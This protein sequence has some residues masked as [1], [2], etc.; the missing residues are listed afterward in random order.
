[1]AK[2]ARGRKANAKKSNF[3]VI[4][5]IREYPKE[6]ADKVKSYNEKYLAEPIEKGKK[7]LKTY[8]KKYIVKTFK[9]GRDYLEKP[10]RKFTD[11][12]D[13]LLARGR[14]MEKDA[15][16]KLDE[17]WEDGRDFAYKIPMV[18][19][20]EKKVSNGLKS[21]P[22]MVNMPNRGEIQKLTRAVETLNANLKSLKTITTL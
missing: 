7:T 2:A 15:L 16:D 10:Y 5:K 21:L 11:R 4:E 22:G 6:I 20:L 19:T 8:N 17:L 3:T 18:E 13:D 1:M 14:D 12:V 9:K